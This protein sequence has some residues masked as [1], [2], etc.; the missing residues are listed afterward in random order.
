MRPRVKR[1]PAR[2]SEGTAENEP[3]R[4]DGER[5]DFHRHSDNSSEDRPR[6]TFH[7]DGENSDRP[8]RIFHRDGENS[9]RPRRTFHRDGENSDRPRRTFHRDGENSDRPRRTFHRDGE[10]SDRP[11]RTFHRDGEN[12]DRPRRTSHRDGENSDRPR[13]TF[14]RDGENNERP[15]RSFGDRKPFEGR[16]RGRRINPDEENFAPKVRKPKGEKPTAK[17]PFDPDAVRLN[18]FIANSGVCSRREADEYIAAGV[19]TIN[20]E[21]VTELG[22]KVHPD[23]D[24]RF[25]GERLKGEKKVYIIM[26]KPK[27]FVT[28]TSDPHAEKNVMDLI[29][30][31]LCPERV[32]SVGRLDKSTTGVLLFTNDGAL[33]ETLTHPSYE[34]KKIY[35]VVLDKNLKKSDFDQ[36]LNGI[37]LEDGFIAADALSYLEEKEDHLG[38]EIHSG[39]N[40]IVRRI[41]ESFGYSVKRLDR[42]YFAGLTKKDLRRGQW[43]FLTEREIGILKM[44]SYE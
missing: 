3:R 27:D 39:R 12:S 13:R 36:I 44:G 33:T 2:R 8:R 41:F 5:R 10:N 35:Q 23:D 7:R 14:H 31:D 16:E 6:R 43:R 21:V 30:K 25:N 11:R 26:N 29:S 20:G 38:I 24:V 32:F 17:Q 34:R 37:E 40:R 15:R 18:K 42:V 4:F 19:V 22:V 28:T 1:G 9:D